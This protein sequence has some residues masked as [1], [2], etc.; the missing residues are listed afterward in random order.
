MKNTEITHVQEMLTALQEAMDYIDGQRD[1]HTDPDSD[2]GEQVPN[3]ACHVYADLEDA[4][5]R[6]EILIREW[7]REQDKAAEQRLSR[8][9]N[10]LEDPD[11]DDIT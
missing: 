1:Y 4:M 9:Y 5:K 7:R 10:F 11:H 2:I 8:R 3:K 6:G